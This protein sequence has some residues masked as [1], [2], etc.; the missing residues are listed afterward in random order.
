MWNDDLDWL[1]LT[2]P[3]RQIGVARKPNAPVRQNKSACADWSDILAGR[4]EMSEVRG[5]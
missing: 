4:S 1:E 5:L 3:V 2:Y